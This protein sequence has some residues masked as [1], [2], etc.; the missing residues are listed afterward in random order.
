MLYSVLR[1]SLDTYFYFRVRLEIIKS[2]MIP[3]S[4]VE[5]QDSGLDPQYYEREE[6]EFSWNEK[7]FS[8]REHE[9]YNDE[10]NCTTTVEREYHDR[11]KSFPS[12]GVKPS[13]HRLYTYTSRDHVPAKVIITALYFAYSSS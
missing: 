11:I 8:D 13:S 6:L 1:V 10:R 9:L 5:D 2:S 4:N 7:I 12:S 3:L